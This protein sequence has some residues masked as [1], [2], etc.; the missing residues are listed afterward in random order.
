MRAT[1]L[2]ALMSTMLPGFFPVLCQSYQQPGQTKESGQQVDGASPQFSPT[3]GN[4]SER[5]QKTADGAGRTREASANEDMLLEVSIAT[6][7]SP[8]TFSLTGRRSEKS[9]FTE[10]LW[11][12]FYVKSLRCAHAR[13]LCVL[14]GSAPE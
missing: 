6:F 1:W 5:S 9:L 14:T 2:T 13:L 12:Y 10:T 7:L 11:T 3:D 8:K 4:Q